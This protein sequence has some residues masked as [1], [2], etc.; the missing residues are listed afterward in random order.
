M[1][2]IITM[3]GRSS[4]FKKAGMMTPKHRLEIGSQTM[5]NYALSSLEDFFSESFI[6]ITRQSNDDKSFIQSECQTLGIDDYEVIELTETTDGQASTAMETDALVADDEPVVIY[7]IDTY[8]EEGTIQRDDID[9]D[10]WIPVFRTS[11]DQWSFVRLD[12]DGN[13]VEVAEKTRISDLATVGLYYFDAWSSFK[14]SYHDTHDEVMEKY[15]E[16]Y[17]CP[18]YQYCIDR[19][20]SVR[21]TEIDSGS[22]N[23]LGTPEDVVNFHPEFADK[24]DL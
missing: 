14:Q 17:I 7:N 16:T 22:I 18:L 1:N 15:G 9:G 23:V 20:D 21:V 5:F 19:G 24:H 4:R 11:G 10:G 2:V 6:F 12:N 13:A 3:A 8:I